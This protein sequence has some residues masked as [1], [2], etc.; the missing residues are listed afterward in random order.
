MIPH[1]EL[2]VSKTH[3][4]TNPDAVAGYRMCVMSYG[5]HYRI[6][7]T[8]ARKIST[9]YRGARHNVKLVSLYA[10]RCAIICLF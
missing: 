7:S 3:K 1:T 10:S 5:I 4:M 6:S 2:S 8:S 9:A